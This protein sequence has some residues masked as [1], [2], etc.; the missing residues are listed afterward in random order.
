MRH[1]EG[2]DKH[3]RTVSQSKGTAKGVSLVHV[4]GDQGGVGRLAWQTG[5]T[6]VAG[7]R[8]GRQL[9]EDTQLREE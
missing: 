3:H 4:D 7:S 1:R 6:F 9:W 5:L 8:Q 2:R